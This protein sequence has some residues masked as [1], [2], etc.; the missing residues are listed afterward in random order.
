MFFCLFSFSH[1]F[2]LSPS[3]SFCLY[4]VLSV[5]Y[6]L[7]VFRRIDATDIRFAYVRLFVFQ[8]FNFSFAW[9]VSLPSIHSTFFTVFDFYPKQKRIQT[10]QRFFRCL[11]NFEMDLFFSVHFKFK[12]RSGIFYVYFCPFLLSR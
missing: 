3:L 8:L 11:S 1:S 9:G 7:R 2:T 5:V 4:V 12:I 10:Y 6:V